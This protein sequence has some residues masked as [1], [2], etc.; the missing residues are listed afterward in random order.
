[1]ARYIEVLTDST[2]G[3]Y[4]LDKYELLQI[5]LLM[6]QFDSAIVTFVCDYDN[7]LRSYAQG[8][9]AHQYQWYSAFD[10]KLI[11]FLDAKMNLTKRNFLQT[12][13]C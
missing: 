3:E 12:I 7:H 6:D 11:E 13:R 5:Y 9:Y 1:M 8:A 2:Y 4:A 10:D